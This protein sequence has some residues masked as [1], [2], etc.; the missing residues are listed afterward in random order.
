MNPEEANI[1]G[2]SWQIGSTLDPRSSLDSSYDSSSIAGWKGWTVKKRSTDRRQTAFCGKPT[3]QG[4]RKG[5]KNVLC[6]IAHN[7]TVSFPREGTSC[8][9]LSNFFSRSLLNFCC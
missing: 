5:V 1:I 4:E 7:K 2:P 6:C 8:A 9:V 3:K